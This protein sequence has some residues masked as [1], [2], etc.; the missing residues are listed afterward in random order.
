MKDRSLVQV[1]LYAAI[2]AVLGLL[3]RFDIPFAAGV[4]ITAQSMGAM[5]AGVMLGAWRGAL[6]MVLML[7]VVALGAPILA[8]GRGG[9]GVF[10]GP[11][12]GFL[13]GFIAAAFVAGWIMQVL[14]KAPVFPAALVAAAVGGILV[15]YA[16]GIAGMALKT[17]LSLLDATKACLIFIPGDA[18][19]AVLTALIA[20]TVARGLPEALL[21]RAR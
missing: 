1:A 19:K 15:M 5:L 18:I 9:L 17:Q 4:P 12:V 7:F 16:F 2:F 3:P 20:Q 8:G 6:A 21:S 11:S 13:F 14:R 10:F